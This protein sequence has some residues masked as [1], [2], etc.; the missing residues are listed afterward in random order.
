MSKTIKVE[1]LI[2]TPPTAKCQAT[3]AV[4]EGLVRSHPDEVRLVVFRRGIDFAPPEMRLEETDS[5][6]A[7]APR[8]VSLQMRTL[9][10]KGT[11]VPSI[12]MDGE[13]YSSFSEPVL[14]ELER[15]VKEILARA[16]A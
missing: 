11:A 13:L 16:D 6:M 14:E 15:K 12:V 8:E 1:V 2:A 4:L 3:V 5:E 10:N 9:I 7:A